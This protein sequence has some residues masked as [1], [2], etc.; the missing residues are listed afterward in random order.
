MDDRH[1]S[2]LVDDVLVELLR[3]GI[4]GN[5]NDDALEPL[6]GKRIERY[7]RLGNTTVVK[8]SSEWRT[9]ARALCVSELEALA[10]VAERDEGD[11]T[12]KPENPMLAAAVEQDGI[13]RA[14]EIHLDAHQIPEHGS[15][16]RTSSPQQKDCD[17]D[18]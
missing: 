5:L 14:A 8:G 12:G 16:L 1:A 18:A 9:L 11:F 10:R 2:G 7:R 17:R 4:A 15:R 6:V 13:G 3:A